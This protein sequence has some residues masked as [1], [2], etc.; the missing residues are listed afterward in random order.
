MKRTKERKKALGSTEE[1]DLEF[2]GGGGF[3]NRQTKYLNF[4]VELGPAHFNL[5][6]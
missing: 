3:A 5:R 1:K 6:D 4:R 2:V